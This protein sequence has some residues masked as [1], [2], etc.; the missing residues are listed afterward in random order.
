MRGLD[1]SI[2]PISISKSPSTK[3]YYG[4]EMIDSGRYL[5]A[6]RTE[7]SALRVGVLCFGR[8]PVE[9]N[10]ISAGD[11]PLNTL[12]TKQLVETIRI[13]I[14]Y[15]VKLRYLLYNKQKTNDEEFKTIYHDVASLLTKL[16]K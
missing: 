15:F 9:S 11:E 2:S 8:S 6:K 3:L 7:K 13:R 16:M 5:G 10:Q 14:Q 1:V 12:F 4:S